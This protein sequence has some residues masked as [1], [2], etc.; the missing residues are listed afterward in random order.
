MSQTK[1][2]KEREA[3]RKHK[4]RLQQIAAR[5]DTIHLEP[6]KR[7]QIQCGICKRTVNRKVTEPVPR[8]CPF[9]GGKPKQW[10][11]KS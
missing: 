7:I 8:A 6:P 11:V 5:S 3:A 2:S 9:C 4:Q 1:R 10:N